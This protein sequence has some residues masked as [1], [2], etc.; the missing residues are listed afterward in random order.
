MCIRRGAR[1]L[2][3]PHGLTLIE[4]LVFIVIVSVGLVGLLSVF[5]VSVRGSADPMIR[6][7][8]LSIAEALL[9]EVELQPFTYCD[10]T[11]AT[12]TTATSAT[13]GTPPTT[14]TATVQGPAATAGQV[15][16]SS[17]AAF[18]NV[19]D[20]AGASGDG[21]GTTGLGDATHAIT[22]L[23]GS[24]VAPL[25]FTASIAVDATATAALG[26]AGNQIAA[27]GTAANMRVARIAVTVRH[28]TDSLTLEG[29]RTRYWPN[30]QSW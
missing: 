13:T 18:N 11:D 9:E 4:L 6:K 20:Y 7:Q 23:N 2:R 10:P 14:C 19:A 24:A 1:Q 8:M 3:C 16:V 29:Y 27:D 15:R 22:D 26:P 30:D 5:N 25:G 17:T 12:W 21:G 28:G